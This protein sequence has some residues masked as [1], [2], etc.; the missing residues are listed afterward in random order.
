MP[1]IDGLALYE[2]VG[3]RDSIIAPNAYVG[4]RPAESRENLLII[5]LDD[6]RQGVT[7]WVP[8]WR[9]EVKPD[10]TLL[11]G[12]DPR[13]LF[14]WKGGFI[15]GWAPEYQEMRHEAAP[16]DTALL[17]LCAQL[18]GV[19]L[20][21]LLGDA[22]R[23]VVPAYDSTLYF[24]DLVEGDQGV[25]AV[26]RKAKQ[27]LDRG[28][29]ALK[30]KIGRGLKWMP[31]P[32][33]TERDIE[34]CRAVRQAVG[35]DVALMVDA[36]RGF[37]RYVEDAADFLMETLDCN[38]VFAEEMVDPSEILLLKDRMRKRGLT[39]PLAGGE[40]G[41]TR[42][43]CEQMWPS[44]PLDILQMDI[45]RT[46]LLEY[47]LV[48]EFARNHG[49][50]LAPHNFGSQIGVLQSA[51]LGKVVPEFLY[52]ECDDSRFFV[53][54]VSPYVIEG[55]VIRLSDAPGLGVRVPDE[56]YGPSGTA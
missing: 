19:P 42:A 47:L 32:E 54:D 23:E 37:T 56:A 35:P 12:R 24:E 43:W 16:L 48:A 11:M 46:G 40:E 17:D 26:T 33:C 28:H 7:N 2:A 6:G 18:E 45:C 15:C 36:N 51:H 27:A 41:D 4:I 50:R 14:A 3:Q 53:Y 31:W 55:G 10:V 44:C 34:V 21:C 52:A 39:V 22:V 25:E 20:W 49:I 1:R 29:R 13:E 9:P 30:I 8:R 5:T 38:L